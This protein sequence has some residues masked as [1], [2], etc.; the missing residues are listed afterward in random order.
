M[1]LL[2]PPLLASFE[3][4]VSRHLV[5]GIFYLL[6]RD[7]IINAHQGNLLHIKVIPVEVP[8]PSLTSA[9]DTLKVGVD[10]ILL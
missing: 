2:C 4:V 7:G 6:F 9:N 5:Y 1:G 3:V 10:D 8:G